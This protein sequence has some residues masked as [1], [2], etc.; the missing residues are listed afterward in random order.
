LVT[1]ACDYHSKGQL[2]AS[3]AILNVLA[4]NDC[5]LGRASLIWA[6]GRI[7]QAVLRSGLVNR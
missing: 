6:A 3:M 7:D 1:L 4:Q 5:D 2:A